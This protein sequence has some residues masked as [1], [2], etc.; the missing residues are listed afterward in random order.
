MTRSRV[1]SGTLCTML[2]TAFATN[3]EAKNVRV[4]IEHPRPS[5]GQ[6]ADQGVASA[7]Q[8]GPT[9]FE[10]GQ[11]HAEGVYQP[12]NQGCLT[13]LSSSKQWSE[14]FRQVNKLYFMD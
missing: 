4:R 10:S 2:V 12:I 7:L 3:R 1:S 5:G 11:S 14:E 13:E 6:G 8:R 9:S